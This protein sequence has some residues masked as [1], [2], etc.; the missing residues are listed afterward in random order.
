MK[1]ISYVKI[2][3]NT[4]GIILAISWL[5]P[6]VYMIVVAFKPE[7]VDSTQVANWFIPP[8]TLENFKMVINH[9]QA[10]VF[11]W[12]LNSGLV[13]TITTSC[14]LVLCTFAA[15]AFSRIKFA[16]K[17]FWFAIIMAGLMIPREATLIPLFVLFKDMGLLGTYFSI[18]APAVA[19]PLGVSI[20]KQF[21]DGIPEALFEAA[22]L[23]GSGWLRTIFTIVI[24]LSKSAL[25]SLG[26]F[27]FLASWN[28]FLWPFISI[29]DPKHVT[30]P[31]GLPLFKS[32]YLTGQ[33]LTM[34]AS[35]LLAAPIMIVFL[36]LQK[37][38]VEGIAMTGVKG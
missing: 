27:I 37:H 14:V 1:K 38:I 23:D 12:V 28:D 20:L 10:N 21:F 35:A 2:I 32:Q 7:T 5:V 3:L 16:G 6:I 18:I 31:V 24:P 30:I 19:A 4:I 33:G 22:K 11:R 9:P 15:F 8:F 26:I 13:S 34:A 36:I 29:S 17:T 25:A